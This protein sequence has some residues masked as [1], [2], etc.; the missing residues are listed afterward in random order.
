MF[1][2]EDYEHIFKNYDPKVIIANT[3]VYPRLKQVYEK[4]HKQAK[5]S[6]QFIVI[7][8]PGEDPENF[9][10]CLL[11]SKCINQSVVENNNFNPFE[12]RFFR[13][14]TKLVTYLKNE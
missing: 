9:E 6:P 5:N 11:F 10:D 2:L 8:K 14:I 13:Y 12:V 7:L 3:K 1:F 4:I